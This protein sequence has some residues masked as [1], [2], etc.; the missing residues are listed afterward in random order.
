MPPSEV[1]Q[2]GLRTTSTWRAGS[3]KPIDRPMTGFT[4]QLHT[5]LPGLAMSSWL[6]KL[7]MGMLPRLMGRMQL[8]QMSVTGLG[9]LPV[10][11]A[12]PAAWLCGQVMASQQVNRIAA[13]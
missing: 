7:A 5:G 2:N 12:M 4:P 8:Q 6:P 11:V 9:N 3:Q 13:M 10:Q 1:R